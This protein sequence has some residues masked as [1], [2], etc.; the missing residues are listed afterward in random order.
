[1]DILGLNTAKIHYI[2][3]N[4]KH[5]SIKGGSFLAF[6]APVISVSLHVPLPQILYSNFLESF[7]RLN[8][9][10]APERYFAV[11]LMPL[12]RNKYRGRHIDLQA[13]EPPI[14]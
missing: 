8:V 5:F 1:L 7:I 14:I 3:A 4:L 10:I 9:F 6:L 12:M 13:L 11:K 2:T